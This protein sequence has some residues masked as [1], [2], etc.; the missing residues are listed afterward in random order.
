MATQA[1]PSQ[2][3]V[4]DRDTGEVIGRVARHAGGWDTYLDDRGRPVL[5]TRGERTRRDATAAVYRA[6]ERRRKATT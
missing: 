1:G 4:I 6:Y 5:L 3:L 2:M